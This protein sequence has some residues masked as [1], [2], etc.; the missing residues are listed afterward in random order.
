MD[1]PSGADLRA[2]APP[3][4]DWT[5]IGYPPVPAGDPDPLDK[6]AEWSAA[7]IETITGRPIASIVPPVDGSTEPNLVPVAEKAITLK[8]LL[9]VLSGTADALAVL[10]QP[11]LRSFTAGSYSETRFSPAEMGGISGRGVE[12]MASLGPEPLA[13]LLILLMTPEKLDEW[14][15]LIT[16]V[17]APAGTFV[18]PDWGHGHGGRVGGLAWGPGITHSWPWG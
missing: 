11:W 3:Q 17:A 18:E 13:T 16:G 7:E 14:R 10:G 15:F 4:L 12:H 6:R 9:D 1:V 8:T 5:A 2:W